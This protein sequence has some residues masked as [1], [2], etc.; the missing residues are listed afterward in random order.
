MSTR[1]AGV[2]TLGVVIA[3]AACAHAQTQFFTDPLS[4]AEFS[5]IGAINNAAYGGQDPFNIGVTG[6]GSVGYEYSIGRLE[7]TTAQW[8]EFYN[9]VLARPDAISFPAQTLWTPTVWGAVRDTSYTGPGTKYRVNPNVA[10]AA[11]LPVGGISW[12]T[13][14]VY[15]N[16]LHNNKSTDASAFL[17]GAYDVSTFSGGFPTFTDQAS[18]S[19]GAR[20]WIP[21]WDEWMKAAHF[22]PNRPNADGSTGG[23]WLYPH[24]SDLAPTYGPPAGFPGGSAANQANSGFNTPDDV[25]YSIPLGAY[26]NVQSPWG[27]LDV[28]GGTAE[29]TETIVS[30][31]AGQ[32]RMTDGSRWGADPFDQVYLRGSDSP[33]APFTRNGL[34]LAS[35]VP[36]PGCL[37]LVVIGG[38]LS[39]RRKRRPTV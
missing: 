7:V 22:D 25:E 37:T 28:A 6:R 4:G 32:W 1:A 33:N 2:V 17:S 35:S 36:S 27:L 19:A 20:Y 26:A 23:W 15:C 29:W 30:N 24:M 3:A 38:A 18:R 5:R 12:R 21:S 8:V 10:N 34:R 16:W 39:S 9:A 11:M 14:A 31:A 13:A